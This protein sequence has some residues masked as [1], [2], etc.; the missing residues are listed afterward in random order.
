ML[1]R[2]FGRINHG[3]FQLRHTTQEFGASEAKE[4]QENTVTGWFNLEA[5]LPENE[6]KI[7]KSQR[8]LEC[9]VRRGTQEGRGTVGNSG[10]EAA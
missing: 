8:Q 5:L 9:A 4:S 7:T 3:A 6:G 10:A 1:K 2:T